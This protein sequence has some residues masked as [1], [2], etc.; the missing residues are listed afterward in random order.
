LS[1]KTFN[2]YLKQKI[3]I[4]AILPGDNSRIADE[5]TLLIMDILV[6]LEDGSLANV[7]AQ[8]IGYKF[9]GQRCACYSSD[10]LLRQYKRV[11]EQKKETFSYRD[12]KKVYTIVLFE[13]STEAFHKFPH[14]HVHYARQKTNTGLDIDFLQEYILIPLDIFRGNLY[15]KGI[16]NQLDAW[17][18]FLSVDDVEWIE[19]LIQQYPEFIPLYKDVYT[20]CMNTEN[21]MGIFSEELKILDKNT[22]LLMIDE[23]QEMI[24]AQKNIIHQK[25]EALSQ[26]D[27]AL[28]QKDEALLQDK[29]ILR[30]K[31]EALRQKNE[32]ILRLRK[33]LDMKNEKC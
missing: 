12:I 8:K 20:L 15:N 3:K 18:T 33:L 14:D 11:R 4:R 26:K 31:D 24:D 21:I 7:E 16:R 9:P 29:E 5:S 6:E 23:M 28:N 25:D 17:L 13:T 27:E 22:T 1:Q 32:E 10:L 19:K 30:Q 2:N